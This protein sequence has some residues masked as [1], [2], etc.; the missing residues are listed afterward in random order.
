MMFD[1]ALDD[2]DNFDEENADGI[3]IGEDVSVES[4]VEEEGSGLNG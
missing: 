4:D 3:G 2:E 1:P